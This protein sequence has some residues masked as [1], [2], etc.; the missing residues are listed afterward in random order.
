VQSDEVITHFADN[1]KRKKT[2]TFAQ[3]TSAIGRIGPDHVSMANRC[4]S[5]ALSPT[6]SLL[7][8]SHPEGRCHFVGLDVHVVD[9]SLA[10]TVS[11]QGRID[12]LAEHV[13]VHLV[14][15]EQFGFPVTVAST[16]ET[17]GEE[18]R[19]TRMRHSV[20]L[21]ELESDHTGEEGLLGIVDNTS[22]LDNIDSRVGNETF[23]SPTSVVRMREMVAIEDSNNLGTSVESEEEVQVVSLGF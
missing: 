12:I 17:K 11:S 2:V 9:S 5:P 23:S 16:E 18:T 6:H 1:D 4:L 10:L 20:N 22:A 8:E 3:A 14:T 19:T 7:P 15:T 13:T 21:V